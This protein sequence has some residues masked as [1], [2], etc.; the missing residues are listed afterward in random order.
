MPSIYHHFH[1]VL[2]TEIDGQGHA[3]NVAFVDWMQD[4]AVA[5][6]TAQ[7]WPLQRYRQE[8][9]SWVARTHQIEYRRPAF[10]HDEIVVRTWVTTM[11]KFSS[12]RKFE[13]LRRSG[14]LLARAE[15]N[16]AFV[17]IQTGRLLAIPE[18]VSQSFGLIAEGK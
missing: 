15:T 13:I 4:A 8:G 7:G 6:S 9:W 18:A 3:N 5:H 11:Q 12:L 1:V 10:V 16:W 2:P 14:E 17:N